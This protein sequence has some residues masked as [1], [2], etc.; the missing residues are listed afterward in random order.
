MTEMTAAVF[1]RA[2]QPLRLAR[3]PRPQP[4][5]HQVIVRVAVCGICGSDLHA[6]AHADGIARW[7]G[8][9]S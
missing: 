7:R 3:L 8:A 1:D 9:R 4:L 6:T 5:A 2:G